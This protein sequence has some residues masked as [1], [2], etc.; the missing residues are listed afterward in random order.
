MARDNAVEYSIDQAQRMFGKGV[1]V[2]GRAAGI[3]SI[4]NYGQEIVKQQD[5]DIRLGQYKPQYTVGLREAY[6]QGGLD[7]GIGWLLEKTGENVASGGAA[8]VGGLASALT[9]PFSVPAAALIGGATLIGS[10]IMGTGETAEEMEQKTGDYN[11][12]VAIGAG[13]IIGILDRFGAGKVIP[14]DELLSMTGKQLIKALGAEGKTDAAKEIGKRIGK[15]IAFEGA[16][17]GVQEGV[18]MGA[19]GITGGEYTGLEIADR[20]L[21][22]TLLGSTMGGATTGGIEALRQGPGVVNQIQDIMSGPGPG[23]LTPQM[24]MAGA[25]LSPDRAQ[26]SLIPDVPKTSAEILMS[27]KAGD[28]TGGGTPVD[29]IMAEDADKLIRDPDDNIAMTDNGRHFSRL[30]LRLQQLPFSAEGLTGR[31]VLQ[32]LGVLGEQDNKMPSGSKKRDY[33][34]SITDVREMD[35]GIP[36]VKTR[37]KEGLSEEDKARFIAA[38]RAKEVP[39]DDLVETVQELDKEGKPVTIKGPSPTF[40]FNKQILSGSMLRDKD[41]NLVLD[42]KGKQKPEFISSPTPSSNKGGDLYQSGLEDFLFKNLD[43]K[44]SKDELL[45][46]YKAYRPEI[47]TRLL[48]SSR[49]EYA[50]GTFGGGSLKFLQRI[51]QVVEGYTEVGAPR[52]PDGQFDTV[53]DDFGI[54]QYTPNQRMLLGRTKFPFPNKKQDDEFQTKNTDSMIRARQNISNEGGG[55]DPTQDQIDAWLLKNEPSTVSELN[56]LAQQLGYDDPFG[57]VLDRKTEGVPNHRYYETESIQVDGDETGEPVIDPKKGEPTA[58][59]HTRGE[60][61]KDKKDGK[62]Y[63]QVS[64]TQGDNQRVYEKEL[65]K[66]LPEPGAWTFDNSSGNRKTLTPS[67]M[68]TLDEAKGATIDSKPEDSLITYEEDKKSLKEAYSKKNYEED[69]EVVNYNGHQ[70][71]ETELQNLEFVQDRIEGLE[72]QEYEFTKEFLPKFFKSTTNQIQRN[73]ETEKNLD[74]DGF[75]GDPEF[76]RNGK[77]RAREAIRAE[78]GETLFGGPRSAEFDNTYGSEITEKQVNEYLLKNEPLLMEALDSH[79]DKIKESVY[80]SSLRTLKNEFY[81]Y[82]VSGGD[83]SKY[84]EMLKNRRALNQSILSIKKNDSIKM[85]RTN[86]QKKF[87]PVYTFLDGVPSFMPGYAEN[88][89]VRDSGGLQGEEPIHT[90]YGQE[91]LEEHGTRGPEATASVRD[92]PVFGSQPH[93]LFLSN[94]M[95][96]GPDTI[97][98]PKASHNGKYY[99]TDSD[100]RNDYESVI[101]I[102]VNEVRARGFSDRSTKFRIA[103]MVQTPGFQDAGQEN[104]TTWKRRGVI[105][106]AR[107]A[108]PTAA[109]A[110]DF[111]EH[112]QNID[113]FILTALSRDIKPS[114]IYRMVENIITKEVLNR[115]AAN[116][117]ARKTSN[118][119]RRKHK[120]ELDQIQLDDTQDPDSDLNARLI[121]DMLSNKAKDTAER[122]HKKLMDKYTKELGFVPV[123]APETVDFGASAFPIVDTYTGDTGFTK[124]REDRLNSLRSNIARTINLNMIN[125]RE[126]NLPSDADSSSAISNFNPNIFEQLAAQKTLQKNTDGL[127]M[128]S[129]KKDQFESARK[130]AKLR[131]EVEESKKAF[132]GFD[133]DGKELSRR[134]SLM[135][136]DLSGVDPQQVKDLIK[137]INSGDISFR[138]PAFG[139]SSSADRFSYRNLIHYAMNEMPNPETGEKGLDGIIIPHR[140]DQH[141]VPGGRGGTA[142][143]FGL[144]KYEAIPKKVLEEIAK[145]TG[146]TLEVDYPM[147]Y[148]G[149]SGKVYPSKRPVTKLIFNKDFKGKAI[150]QYKK[151]GIFEKFR[152]VS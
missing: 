42:S 82:G 4:F 128:Q 80:L 140:L 55:T 104:G 105:K 97:L 45:N 139:E 20:I 69:V 21:E 72:E 135:S 101:E 49:G 2:I 10:G 61:V 66:A 12:A 62:Y 25:Q 29:P 115:Q 120:N 77:K 15:S 73:I 129:I 90:Y 3:E 53:Y 143:T 102:L 38:K 81:T 56:S 123:F 13:T 89:L 51:P 130:L 14:K 152:K 36:R 30:A 138:T 146:A 114:E 34:G 110:Q 43:S 26:M 54:V 116:I 48:L 58:Q 17:E 94:H 145:E 126:L 100:K 107:D 46:E 144:N 23:G 40:T 84:N 67:D 93:P 50:H 64:E 57:Q 96:Y 150:A 63:A 122:T 31:Q 35:T 70:K 87:N 147:E 47:K 141:E 83:I 92:E 88:K 131:Q 95:M 39:P 137:A 71:A 24:A 118:E 52:T 7:D 119:V 99:P 11:E 75:S 109:E 113:S 68:R 78:R 98:I 86:V 132:E 18:V 117:I 124:N 59:S 142:K 33:I 44:I 60:T 5:E 149:R 134:L 111:A 121:R 6:N 1:E 32:E 27:E 103:D 112:T 22:G 37:M 28:E 8:L 151:G 41:G 91:L 136:A 127:S 125:P 85:D 74:D 76:L 133:P 108:K 106:P 9:A 16:T 19:T 148:Q 65:D 79:Y